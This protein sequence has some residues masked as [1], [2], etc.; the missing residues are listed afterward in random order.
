VCRQEAQ[1]LT[2]DLAA[3]DLHVTLKTFPHYTLGAR[4]SR[5]GEPFDLAS[6]NWIADYP[7][8]GEMLSGMLDNPSTYPT[9]NDPYYQRRL[10]AF[11]QLSGPERYLAYGKLAVDLA[12]AGAPLIAYGNSTIHEFFSARIGC[13]TYGFYTG[14]DLSALCIKRVGH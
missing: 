13:K 10:A 12:R 8:P 11:G 14:A 6:L 3:I 4:I 7:D 1:I 2:N 5:P 9:F